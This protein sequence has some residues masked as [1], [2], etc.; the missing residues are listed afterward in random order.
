MKTIIDKTYYTVTVEDHED[1][2]VKIS[3]EHNYKIRSLGMIVTATELY[4][5]Y[6]AMR[7]F[8]EEKFRIMKEREKENSNI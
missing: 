1:N 6:Q 8:M 4:G 7:E 2:K 3:I 5:V